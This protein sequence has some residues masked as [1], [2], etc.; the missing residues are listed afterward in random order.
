MQPKIGIY[1]ADDLVYSERG[2]RGKHIFAKGEAQKKKSQPLPLIS[3]YS[4]N[5]FSEIAHLFLFVCRFQEG[6]SRFDRS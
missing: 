6:P 4:Q 5:I 1:R 3:T 2:D